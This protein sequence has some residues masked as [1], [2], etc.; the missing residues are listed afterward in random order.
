MSQLSFTSYY[1]RKGIKIGT[2]VILSFIIL[3][4][5][6]SVFSSYWRKL[7]PPPEPP[8]DTAYGKLPAVGFPFQKQPKPVSFL[9][10]TVEGGLPTNLP[11]KAKVYYISKLGGR[12]AKLD[13][14]K[15]I[16]QKLDLNANGEKITENTYL[17][18][19]SATRT[20]LEINVLTQNFTYSYDYIHDQTLINP[21]PLPSKDQAVVIADS[22]L[23]RINKLTEE[24]KQGTNDISYWRIKGEKLIPAI[25]ASE[26]DFIEVKLFRKKIEDE[27]QIM[28]PTYPESLV[29]FLITSKDIQGKQVVEAKFINFEVDREEFAEYPLLPIEEAWEKVKNGD[30]FL[31]SYDGNNKE[32]VK[33]RNIYLAYFDPY[34]STHFLQ[35]IYVFE[36]DNN[37]V[38]YYP[39]IPPEWRE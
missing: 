8:P 5:G 20:Q 11:D 33:I 2:I 36:G 27:Y 6:Y 16:A 9:L 39:A 35:P 29:S 28:P 12:F 18:K 10:E 13:E 21:P 31:S 3:K 34:Q 25:S 32:N 4:T 22:F 24:L 37:F 23:S 38:G 30:Y 14:S 19:N 26:A 15:N 7:H 17:F 1:I